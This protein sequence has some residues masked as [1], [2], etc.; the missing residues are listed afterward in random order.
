MSAVASGSGDGVVKAWDLVSREH[1]FSVRAHD[2]AVNGLT[3]TVDGRLLS[4]SSDKVIKLWDTKS[5]EV[6]LLAALK[7]TDG[8]LCK[9]IPELRGSTLSTIIGMILYLLQLP[10]Q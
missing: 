9:Y 1:V 7:L 10:L 8:S 6:F 3:Y 5:Q 2:G 4:C